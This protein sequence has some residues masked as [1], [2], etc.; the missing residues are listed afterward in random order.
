MRVHPHIP[1]GEIA[2]SMPQVAKLFDVFGVD[3]V[4]HGGLSLRDACAEAG[5]DPAIVK[6]SIDALPRREEEGPG[7]ADA[8]LEEVIAE[9]RDRRHAKVRAMIGDVAALIA[10]APAGETGLAALR[11]AFHAIETHVEPHFVREER[12]LFPMIQQVEDCW[13]KGRP[14]P[15]SSAGGVAK[16]IASLIEDHLALMRRVARLR[17]A[18][19]SIHDAD[20]VLSRLLGGI[21]ELG[22]ELRD[23]AHI[24]N[25][26]LFPRAIATEAALRGS[27]H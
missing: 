23:H 25:N 1:V 22:Q 12:T 10:A 24:E 27:E 7:L 4:M 6:A 2:A 16:P 20:G 26:V 13:K 15:M 17:E 3:Y 11:E 14:L 19:A 21:A 18:A 5:V 8:T 9:L